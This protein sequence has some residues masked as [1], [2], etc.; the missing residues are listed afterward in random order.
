MRPGAV[1]ALERGCLKRHPDTGMLLMTGRHWKGV[2]DNAGQLVP[3]GEIRRDTWVVAEPV[4]AAVTTLECLHDEQL[5]FPSGSAPAPRP[6][7]DSASGRAP[8]PC[9]TT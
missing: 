3:E 6:A 8:E 1:L 2:R 5:L 4:A 7:H 9:P